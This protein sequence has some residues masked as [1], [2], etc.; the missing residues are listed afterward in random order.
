MGRQD[1]KVSVT[2]IIS[3]DSGKLKLDSAVYQFFQPNEEIITVIPYGNANW[4]TTAKIT[5]RTPDYTIKE[6]FLKIVKGELAEERVLGEYSCMSE[7][8]RTVPSIVPMPYSAGNCL[9]N[10]GCFFLSE[11]VPIVHRAPDAVQ[12][13]EQIAKLHRDSISPT[14]KFGFSTTPYDGKLP[15]VVDW[16]S[17]W[18]S[19]YGKLL[20]G[21]YLLDS[22]FN[23]K[24]QALEE[25]MIV[26]LDR[27]IPRLLGALEEEGRIIKPCLIHGDLWEDNIG[28]DL[29][30]GDIFIFDCC[31][32]YAHH[33]MGVAM[34]RVKHHKMNAPEYRAEYFKNYPPD[35]P[36]AECDDRNR[37]YSI[38]ENLMYSALKPGHI[39]RAQALADMEYLICKYTDVAE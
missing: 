9:D 20:Y 36:V 15:L 30:T 38:K 6:Y 5:T 4:A 14:G 19:F 26:T 23:D 22:K 35:E 3:P 29:R 37:L 28:T 21:V 39:S 12:L 17:S 7:L 27:V 8:Y 2:K 33:E 1:V 34:W 16:D 31:A 18:M 11:F 32:Y 24:W 10:K 25:A 13:G